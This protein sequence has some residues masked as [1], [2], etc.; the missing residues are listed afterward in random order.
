MK[1]NKSAPYL[2]I[3]IAKVLQSL[4]YF[5][6]YPNNSKVA[7]KNVKVL[8]NWG[9]F[10]EKSRKKSHNAEKTERGTLWDFSTSILS[11]KIR[12]IESG[13]LLGIF[14]RKSHNV[15]KTMKGDLFVS[16]GIVNYARNK[17]KLFRLGCL[18][19]MFHL[20]TS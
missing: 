18:S 2:R 11:Q 9:P 16:D 12:K 15:E 3:K 10:Y 5:L 8:V 19:Q 20:D 1:S 4:K 6:Q 13:T 7:P 14:F 17:E